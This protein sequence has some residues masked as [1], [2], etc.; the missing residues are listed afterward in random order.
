MTITDFWMPDL[1]GVEVIKKVCAQQPNLPMMLMP[2]RS[3]ADWRHSVR[4]QF[5]SVR[6]LQKLFANAQLRQV[7][8][9]SLSRAAQAPEDEDPV[10]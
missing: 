8:R 1:D 3:E 9:E 5:P 6:F 10:W 7:V 4:P 2:G